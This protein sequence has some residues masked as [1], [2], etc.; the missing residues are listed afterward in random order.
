VNPAT[1]E[2]TFAGVRFRVPGELQPAADT[3]EVLHG[4]VAHFPPAHEWFRS[5]TD[6]AGHHLSLF[7]W[8]ASPR[9]RGH[10]VAAESWAPKVAG[11]TARV[12]LVTTFFRVQQD[13][14]VAHFDGPRHRQYLVYTNVLDRLA[15]ERMLAG[16]RF[17]PVD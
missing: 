5:F 3:V 8:D 13:L 4:P 1:R 11:R 14:L 2:A 9:D 15:F 17:V 7:C 6:T 16:M 10:M 12:H